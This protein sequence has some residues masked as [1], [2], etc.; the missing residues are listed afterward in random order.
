MTSHIPLVVVGLDASNLAIAIV[1]KA[2]VHCFGVEQAAQ[3]DKAR[4][5]LENQR[6]LRD[7]GSVIAGQNWVDG[8]QAT[9]LLGLRDHHR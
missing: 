4:E 2:G 7:N 9:G 8:R 6:L 5:T 1:L 3:V